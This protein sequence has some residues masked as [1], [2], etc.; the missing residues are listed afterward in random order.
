MLL[1]NLNETTLKL[2]RITLISNRLNPKSTD[3]DMRSWDKMTS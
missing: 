3:L 1:F 2:Q